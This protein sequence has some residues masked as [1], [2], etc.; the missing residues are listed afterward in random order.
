M[1]RNIAPKLFP[2]HGRF[3]SV[4]F[5]NLSLGQIVICV[6]K[7]IPV[8]YWENGRVGPGADIIGWLKGQKVDNWAL[9]SI[10]FFVIRG[11]VFA[12]NCSF[13]CPSGWSCF[14]THYVYYKWFWILPLICDLILMFT[15]FFF[16]HLSFDFLSLFN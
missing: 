3:I 5:I 15:N 16:C 13:L 2:N 12:L 6:A 11:L 4:F 10:C 14:G 7:F 9:L 1:F 8:L